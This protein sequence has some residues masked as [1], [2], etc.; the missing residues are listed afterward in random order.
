MSLGVGLG[1]GSHL[2]LHPPMMIIG[3]IRPRGA[4]MPAARTVRMNQIKKAIAKSGSG[5]ARGA[6]GSGWGCE[7]RMG[8]R[9]GGCGLR[10]VDGVVKGWLTCGFRVVGEVASG[11]CGC[12]WRMYV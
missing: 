9:V 3:I 7:W 6:V 2:P 1:F 10:V 4:K 5:S 12:E 11:V 8:L